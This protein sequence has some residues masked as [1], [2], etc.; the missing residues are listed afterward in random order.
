LFEIAATAAMVPSPLVV[1]VPGFAG[2]QGSRQ[3]SLPAA[4]DDQAMAMVD[5]YVKKRRT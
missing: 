5:N 2:Q 4:Q 3:T 1:I